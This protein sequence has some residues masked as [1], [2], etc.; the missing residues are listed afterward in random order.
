MRQTIRTLLVAAAAGLIATGCAT[1]IGQAP[2]PEQPTTVENQ[3]STGSRVTGGNN[4]RRV[5]V[6]KR[7]DIDKSGATSVGEL[8]KGP[9]RR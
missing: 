3:P 9:G 5:Q 2:L 1:P 8:L 7:D 4:A 6:Y